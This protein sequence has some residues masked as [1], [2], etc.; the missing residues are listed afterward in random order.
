LVTGLG[1]LWVRGRGLYRLAR[2]LPR[3][4]AEPLTVEQAAAALARGVQERESRF[5]ERLRHS[6]YGNPRSPYARLLAACNCEY[7]DV[8]R[9]VEAEGLDGALRRLALAGVYLSFDEFKCRRPVI[10]GSQTFHF[11]PEDFTDL[12]F[13][14]WQ[15]QQTSGTTGPPVRFG[16][17][18]EL[19]SQWSLHWCVFFAAN[20]VLGAPLIFWTP[21]NA[22]NVGPQLACAK[23]R[24]RVDH[25]FVSQRMP[26][27]VDRAYTWARHAISRHYAG[28]PL[29]RLVA[30]HDV[31][32][33]LA[34]AVR[35]LRRHGKASISTT[36]SAA[37]RLSLAAQDQKVD[38]AGLVFLLGAE[39]LTP[40]RRQT[41]EAARAR[42]VPLYGST[43][44][45]WTGGQCPW[46]QAPDE[47]HV[48]RDLHAVI[49]DPASEAGDGTQP[50]RLLFTTLVAGRSKFI[51]NTDIGDTGV[52]GWRRCGCL[53]DRLGCHQ[54]IHTIRSADKLT[55]FGVTI[56][57][58]D[59]HEV[60]ENV[61][62]RRFRAAATDFQLV[63][64]RTESG[65]PQYFL[66]V[67]PRLA[68]LEAEAVRKAFLDELGRRKRHYAFMTAI[69]QQERLIEVLRRPPLPAPSG[70]LLAFLRLRD[71]SALASTGLAA[72]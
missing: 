50:A 44:A 71:P 20:D 27:V 52:I 39:P 56:W 15:G 16:T 61:L 53:Y 35:L 25:W 12:G 49:T 36:P 4:L 21:G 22:G 19:V 30:Y 46:P 69:W 70:K 24:Q 64:T 38:L 18:L 65:L 58:A 55:E 6:V 63:E 68:G 41:I 28:L 17:S 8:V 40:A 33:V 45:V 48:L 9:L 5:L 23:F 43:E 3:F 2:H 54:T 60:L 29:P 62:A 47:V 31:E 37:V 26:H 7:G 1:K 11:D 34:D 42:P 10:R 57:V 51:L 66:L 14:G 59:V 32:L 72:D 13:R 67:H